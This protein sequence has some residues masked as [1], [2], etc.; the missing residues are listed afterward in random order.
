[1]RKIGFIGILLVL[2]MACED[3]EPAAIE[4]PAWLETRIAELESSNC[5]GCTITR[6]T[7]NEEFF[8]HVYC[9]TWSCLACE[10]Y[11]YNGDL[12]T[13]GEDVDPADFE[14]NK[15]RPVKIWEC[16]TGSESP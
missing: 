11:H 7:Y 1:M 13:W 6:Y 2:M 16:N 4:T 15:T 9:N 10:V 3:R 5:Q 8:Y 12:V 14:Q